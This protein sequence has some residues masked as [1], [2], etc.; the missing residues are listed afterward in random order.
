M[1]LVDMLNAAF[2]RLCIQRVDALSFGFPPGTAYFI[3]K[4]C[5]LLFSPAAEHDVGAILRERLGHPR[6]YGS[7][8]SMHDNDLFTQKHPVPSEKRG[9]P[10]Q[11]RR[12]AEIP[13]N[14]KCD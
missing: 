7:T 11:D 13:V 1:S 8:G 12:G 3:V 10:E 6:S 2:D 5:E 4:R 14:A 9:I